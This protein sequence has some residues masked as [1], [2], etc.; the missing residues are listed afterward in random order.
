[1]SEQLELEVENIKCGGCAQ[2]IQD[3]LKT[4]AGI[5]AVDVD[6]ASGHLSINGNHLSKDAI[7]TKLAELGFPI[8]G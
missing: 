7:G 3:G 2:T 6:I 1:M 8:K 4:L 5:D